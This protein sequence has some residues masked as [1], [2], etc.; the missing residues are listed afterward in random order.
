MAGLVLA[1]HVVHGVG[2]APEKRGEAAGVDG[3]LK[4]GHNAE[5]CAVRL[6]RRNKCAG[7]A[8]APRVSPHPYTRVVTAG[9]VPAIHVVH[10]VRQAPEKRGEAAGVNGRLKAGHNTDKSA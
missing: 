10:G 9:L 8:G 5:T 2:Q 3:R 1:I 6:K 4:A 7:D